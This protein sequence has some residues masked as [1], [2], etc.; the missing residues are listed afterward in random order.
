MANKK[1]KIRAWTDKGKATVKA[2]LFHPMETG[3]R[4]NKATGKIIPAHFITEVKC[5]HNGK[6]VLTCL[7]GP[8]VSKNPFLS[9]RFKNAKAGDSLKISWKD[10]KGETATTTDKIG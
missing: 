2:I 4:K 6:T 10:N 9:F 3:L 7:W 8:G 1:I 5:E